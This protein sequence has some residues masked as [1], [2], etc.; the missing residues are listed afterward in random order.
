MPDQIQEIRDKLDIVDVVSGYVPLKKAG[1]NYKALCPFHTEK[2]PSFMV[3]P[4]L[5]IYKCFGCGKGGNI[6][7][8]IMEIEGVEF[9]DALQMMADRAGIKLQR[10]APSPED[11]KRNR[12]YKINELANQF[13]RYL[14]TEHKLG[15]KA[16]GYLHQRGITDDS[17]KTFEIGYAP[18]SWDSLGKYLLSKKYSLSDIIRAGLVIPKES[19]G[20]FYDRFRGRV[21][22]ALRDPRNRAVGFSGRTISGDE[23]KYINTPETEIFKKR[24]FLYGL[25]ITRK[26][27]KRA[28]Q[29][30]VV[31]G[32]FDLVSPYQAGTKNIVASKGTSLTEGQI[33][34]LKRLA[35]D[36]LFCY[37]ADA[38]GDA[39][40]KR[41]IQMAEEA[42]LNVKVIN[43]PTGKDPDE[44]VQKDPEGWKKAVENAISIYDF[45]FKTSLGKYDTKTALGK[46][47]A[48]K[49]LLPI[50]ASIPDPIEKDHYAK[51][52]ALEL[53][54][55]E[56][57]LLN[58][59]G[60]ISRVDEREKVVA[61]L[62]KRFE[63]TSTPRVVQEYVLALM[64]KSPL[65]QVQTTLHKLGQKDFSVPKL[66]KIFAAFKEYLS[67]RKKAFNIKYFRDKLS[68]EERV[69]LDE[70]YLRDFSFLVENDEKLS[71]EL[72]RVVEVLKRQTVKRELSELSRKIKEA[73]AEGRAKR[74]SEL[75]KEF[76]K[77]SEKLS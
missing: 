58:A 50:I 37:D 47:R 1:R 35:D 60:K 77:L 8:F 33:A 19:G 23:A 30:V 65:D 62:S 45:Y 71:G 73:E 51:R 22:L 48:A 75:R 42:G 10:R 20:G 16:L 13:Y 68:E 26:E 66:Q 43:L 38:A 74:L 61:D 70:L 34:L 52:L 18:K 14:L 39:A 56:G 69:I 11:E 36:L 21:V 53:D 5:Q 3:S 64:L 28:R 25:N 76:K 29:A 49:E 2:T 31:E 32:D 4:E 7:N 54:V 17:I 9:R 15:K 41:G 67:G 55:S 24:N 6:Y 44:C 63:E 72:S 46:K 27:I 57:S 40:A 59:L 12:L